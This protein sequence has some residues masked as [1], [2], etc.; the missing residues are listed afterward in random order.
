MTIGGNVGLLPPATEPGV[1]LVPEQDLGPLAA[2]AATQGI[3]CVRVDLGN[4]SSKADFLARV[5]GALGFRPGTV[6]NW[7][8]LADSLGDL[9]RPGAPGLAL[10][11]ANGDLLRRAAAGD[12]ETALDVLQASAA[13]W[14]EG[15]CPLWVFVAL[16]EVERRTRRARR[17]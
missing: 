13:E 3:P 16:A 2:A 12:F 9:R 5:S 6:R 15:R 4:C 17:T 1:H 10:L 11:L 8:A 14:A 7:D